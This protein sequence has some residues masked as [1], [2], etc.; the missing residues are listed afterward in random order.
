M[1]LLGIQ[2][3][4]EAQEGCGPTLREFK[5]KLAVNTDVLAKVEALRT[6]VEEFAVKFPLPGHDEL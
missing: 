2:L 6:E 1:S 3:A 4:I 5:E